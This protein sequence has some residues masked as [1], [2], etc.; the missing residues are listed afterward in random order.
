MNKKTSANI[1]YNSLGVNRLRCFCGYLKPHKIALA[2]LSERRK[3]YNRKA[4]LLISNPQIV[5]LPIAQRCFI[6]SVMRQFKKHKPK[7]KNKH[8]TLNI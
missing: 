6:F 8:L 7:L 1:I 4:I 2:I 3:L 5:S